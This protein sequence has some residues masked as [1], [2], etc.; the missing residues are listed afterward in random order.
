MA[1][2]STSRAT[3][4]LAARRNRIGK[5]IERLRGERDRIDMALQ[6]LSGKIPRNNGAQPRNK[7]RG[8]GSTGARVATNVG[9]LTQAILREKP[10]KEWNVLDLMAELRLRRV[11]TNCADDRSFYNSVYTCLRRLERLDIAQEIKEPGEN[12]RFRFAGTKS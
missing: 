2:M 10:T 1:K 7:H 3:T 12:L 8:Q 9:P 11:H 6:A 4:I 5:Q